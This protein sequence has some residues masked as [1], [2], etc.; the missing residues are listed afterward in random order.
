MINPWTLPITA[1]TVWMAALQDGPTL[2]LALV[3]A[4]VFVGGARQDYQTTP[5]PLVK[6]S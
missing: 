3:I 4:P 5:F 6:I 2:L 1:V